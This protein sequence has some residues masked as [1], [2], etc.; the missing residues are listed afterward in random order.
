MRDFINRNRGK[1]TDWGAEIRREVRRKVSNVRR[2]GARAE[3]RRN[4][5]S[6]TCG[7]LGGVGHT[8]N[9]FY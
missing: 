8:R 7:A 1:M 5:T 3:I 9:A 4:A 2:L 6:S